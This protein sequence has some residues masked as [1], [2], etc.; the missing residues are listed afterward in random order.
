MRTSLAIVARAGPGPSGGPAP[1]GP[2][3]DV[4]GRVH[5]SPGLP[6]KGS[7]PQHA[8]RVLVCPA[9]RNGEHYLHR[10]LDRQAKL[11]E[12]VVKGGR[13]VRLPAQPTSFVGRA[14]E[15]HGLDRLVRTSR[16]VTITGAAGMGKTRLAVEVACRLAGDVAGDVGFVGLAP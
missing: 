10:Y 5:A 2:P 1:A 9:I 8:S 6:G 12:G 11:L 14:A 3:H 7:P 15:L 16:L 4:Q 13:D